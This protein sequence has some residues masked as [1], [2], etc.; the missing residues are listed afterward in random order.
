LIAVPYYGE[1]SF[2]YLLGDWVRRPFRWI[3]C[4]VIFVGAVMKVETA[5]SIGDVF[6][7]MMAF[8]NLIGLVGLAGLAIASV[9][10]YLKKIDGYENF[11]Q[12]Q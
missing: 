5:W 1:I 12:G 4:L 7:G 2:S 6:N 3:F 11:G 8:T 10:G 9:K